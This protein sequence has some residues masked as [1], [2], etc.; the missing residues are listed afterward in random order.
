[1]RRAWNLI[2]APRRIEA[3]DGTVENAGFDVIHFTTQA[4]FLTAVP[5]IYQP[6][7]LQH[8]HLPQYF[9]RRVRLRRELEYRTYC[10]Q[11]A[12][13]VAMSTWGREDLIRRYKLQP[14]RVAVVPWAA[15]ANAEVAPGSERV[16]QV[17]RRYSLPDAFAFFPSRTWPHKNHLGLIEAIALLRRKFGVR[18]HVICSGHRDE[19]F[20]KIEGHIQKFQLNDQVRFV[21]F[22]PEDDLQCLYHASRCVV[23]PTKFEGWGLPLLEAFRA[24]T[25]VACSRINPLREQAADAALLFN[26]D[27][28]EEMAATI[29]RLWTDGALRDRLAAAGRQRADLFSWRQTARLFRAHY[30][31]LGKR[32][33]APEDRALLSSSPIV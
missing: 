15:G 24:G 7:D 21:G 5:S 1:V 17:R 27:N 32:T 14:E 31:K 13:V 9:S 3:S 2:G 20:N 6:H 22:V 11:A 4:A 18:V 25:P 16:A 23:F 28:Q 30:R 33:L 29:L 12:L 8:L 10:E 19:F 26:P